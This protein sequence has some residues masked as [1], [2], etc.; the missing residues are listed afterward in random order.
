MTKEPWNKN[1]SVGQKKAFTPRQLEMLREFLINK[2]KTMELAL[3]NIGID[4]M[5]RYSDVSKLKVEDVLDWKGNV[6]DEINLKQ[7]KTKNS[8]LV[9]LSTPTKKSV[10]KWVTL[11]KKF[12]DDYLFSGKTKMGNQ[13]REKLS[14]TTYTRFI[15]EWA[16]YLHLD[17]KDYASHSLRRTRAAFM[18]KEGVGI[19]IIRILLGQKSIEST[20]AYLGI[21]QEEAFDI[22]KKFII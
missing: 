3:L 5:L 9:L 12:E 20:R 15:K 16:E 18:Y 1:K 11:S 13:R 2:G 21:E 6:K 14:R 22:G 8:H 10:K 17:P 4:T 7:K 19:E